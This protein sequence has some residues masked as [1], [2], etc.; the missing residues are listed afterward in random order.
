MIRFKKFISALI[1]SATVVLV[2]CGTVEDNISLL[3]SPLL[4]NKEHEELKEVLDKLLPANVEYLTPRKVQE[5]QSIFIDDINKDGKQE[6]FVLYKESGENQ[7]ANILVLQKDN[8]KWNKIQNEVTIYNAFDYFKIEDLNG[9]GNKEVVAGIVGAKLESNKELI[10]YEWSKEGLGKKL[11]GNYEAVHVA[12]YNE[13]GVSDILLLEGERNKS[14]RAELYSYVNGQLKSISKVE[15]DPSAYHENI[16]SGKLLDGKNALFID[17]GLGAHSMLT[18]IVSYNNGKLIKI[19]DVNDRFLFKAYPVYS[20]DINNDG[21]IEVAGM[22]IPKG[23]EDSAFAEIPFIHV[24]VDYRVNG[25]RQT[26]EERYTN[27]EKNFYITIPS[28]LYGNVTIEKLE[29]GVR[30][31]SS[32]DKKVLFQVKWVNKESFDAS[33][34]KLRETKD[35]VFYTDIKEETVIPSANF[36]LFED[37]F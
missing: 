37:E 9:D 13:D 8:E 17:S 35:T 19:G 21:V 23:W 31:L 14:Q 10:I 22:Y 36:H 1:I 30:L 16:V 29:K 18:E 25:T 27:G 24:Y 11:E 3:Q 20:K 28:E 34:V 6:V 32:S 33:K 4:T 2:G 5:K 7:Q 15:L 26:I 12:D